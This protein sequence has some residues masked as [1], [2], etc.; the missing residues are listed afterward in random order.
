[1][2]HMVT[3]APAVEPIHLDDIKRQLRIPHDAE[4]TLLRG[5]LTAARQLWE[6]TAGRAIVAQTIVV[7]T[8]RF[9]LSVYGWDLRGGFVLPR[10][11]AIAVQSIGYV[12]GQGVDQILAANQYLLD[13]FVAPHQIIPRYGISWPTARCQPNAVT[14]TYTAGYLTPFIA[15]IETNILT[16]LGRA[17]VDGERTRVS[18]SGGSPPTPLL[19]NTDYWIVQSS[20]QTCGVS[21]T[22]GGAP[23]DLQGQGPGTHFLGEAPQPIL[24]EIKLW[25]GDLYDAREAAQSHTP[26]LLLS[27][28]YRLYGADQ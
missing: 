12:D 21:L 10:S 3:I 26:R 7:A 4:D 25:T 15:D 17:P 13:T 9:P 24:N 11:P 20:G 1:M 23:I 5:Y 22:Q 6:E 8:E 27:R 16:L 28:N 18:N 2:P 14:I 19:L